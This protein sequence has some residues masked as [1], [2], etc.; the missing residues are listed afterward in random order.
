MVAKWS[1]RIGVVLLAALLSLPLTARAYSTLYVLGDSL[2]DTG[3]LYDATSK[4]PLNALIPQL[5]PQS[6]YF[7][8]RF[9]DGPVYAEYLWSR[10]GF[11]GSPQPSSLGGTDYAYGGARS[12]YHSFDNSV[13]GFN[14]VGGVS[15][16]YD[17]SL[18]GQRDALLA[19]HA[20]GLDP[21]ALYTVWEG[22]NDVSDAIGLAFSGHGG[23]AAAL[24]V[25]AA[26]D[27]VGV[28]GDLVGAGAH[29]LLIPNVPNLG[30]VPEV[31]ALG[32]GAQ[33]VASSMTQTYNDLVSKALLSLAVDFVRLDTYGILTSLVH[34]P[35]AWGLPAT[36]NVDDACF[37]GF[38]GVPGVACGDPENYVFWDSI[39][40]SAAVHEVLGKLAAQA[41][42]EPASAALV[43]L[44]LAALVLARRR[45]AAP[46]RPLALAA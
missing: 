16:F 26:T 17:F 44:A 30:L 41:V 29:Y 3:N 1:T 22:S 5:L 35:P 24:L 21:D 25:Q 36:A 12:R 4:P 2:S 15:S 39:H 33:A 14:P 38:V 18:L 9:S 19:D 10:L 43:A 37:T 28:I 32:G 40:P 42:P 11:S 6:P 23:Q 8:G 27:F 20:G 31:V 13:P 46:L 45:G 7:A 34:N